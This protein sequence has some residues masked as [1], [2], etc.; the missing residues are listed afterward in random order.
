VRLRVFGMNTLSPLNNWQT[1]LKRAW[2]IRLM[3][4]AAV[5]SGFEFLLPFAHA[6][7]WLDWMP[8]GIF[9]ALSFLTI[10]GAFVA[11]LLAQRNMGGAA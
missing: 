8:I 4:G 5:L 9:A 6:V 3:V 1:I 11:R 10:V 2:S 7:G